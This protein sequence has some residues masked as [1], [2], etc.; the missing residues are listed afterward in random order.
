MDDRIADASC[1]ILAAGASQRF[2]AAKMQHRLSSGRTILQETI[3]IYGEIFDRP[4][5]VIRQDDEQLAEQLADLPV[6]LILSDKSQLGMSESLKAGIKSCLTSAGC[7]VVLGDMPYVQTQTIEQIVGAAKADNIVVPS[8]HGRPGNPVYFGRD[9][10]EQF[11]FLKGDRGA[12]QIV[13][14]NFASV[15]RLDT[16]DEGLVLDIDY[17]AAIRDD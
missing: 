7:L 10:Y 6:E 16:G 9:F 15:V 17:P 2:G 4:K 5:V 8:F 13:A 11:T 14:S 3:Q 12:K 1:L